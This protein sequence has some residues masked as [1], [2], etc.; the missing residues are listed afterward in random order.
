MLF[1]EGE[2]TEETARAEYRAGR[3]RDRIAFVMSSRLAGGDHR[4]AVF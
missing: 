4:Q 2:G 3:I 1:R